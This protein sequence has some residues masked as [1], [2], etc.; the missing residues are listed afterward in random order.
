MTTN[1]SDRAAAPLALRRATV[2]DL[3]AI[4]AVI[5]AAYSRY[6]PRMDKP[7]APMSRDYKPSV[8]A[9]TT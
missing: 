5:D 2:D 7:P 4:R 3:P 1:P 9:G 6:L 8:E